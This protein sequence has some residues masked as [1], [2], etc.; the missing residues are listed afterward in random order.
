LTQ[1]QWGQFQ[2]TTSAGFIWSAKIK[3][4]P[5][6][7]VY[8]HDAYIAGNGLLHASLFGLI[9]LVNQQGVYEMAHG[10]LIRFLAETA[11]YPTALL[12][13]QGVIW[14]EISNFSAKA[15]IVDGKVEATLLFSFNENGLIDSVRSEA[16]E[17]TVHGEIV[18]TP[19]EG[20]WKN[21]QRCHGVLIP[22]EGEVAW[23]LP[24]GRK[25]YWRGRVTNIYYEFSIGK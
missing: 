3:L 20:R 11:W 18:L 6:V 7:S 23:I 19:W 1:A 17:R 5:G 8:V 16:R 4:V 15:T 9:P 14:E 21:Y 13:S 12:P 24:E 25:P 10:E 2:K 22:M